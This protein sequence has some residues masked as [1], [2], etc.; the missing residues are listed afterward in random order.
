MVKIVTENAVLIKNTVGKFAKNQ[1]RTTR[2]HTWI[3]FK[4]TKNGINPKILSVILFCFLNWFGETQPL[5]LILILYTVVGTCRNDRIT[6][7]SCYRFPP[8][9]IKWVDRS[10]SVMELRF[11]IDKS[12]FSGFNSYRYLIIIRQIISWG[13]ASFT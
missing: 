13:H 4:P 3:R 9:A 5:F 10:T 12:C 8:K 6:P 7:I 1:F 11:L 2:K